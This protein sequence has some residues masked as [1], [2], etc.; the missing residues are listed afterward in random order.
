ML[1]PRLLPAGRLAGMQKRVWT[2][3]LKAVLSLVLVASLLAVAYGVLV[4]G[5]DLFV[6]YDEWD[7]IGVAL[8]VVILGVALPVTATSVV[9]LRLLKH[10]T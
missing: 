8:G 4:L 2:G 7:G 5:T 10:R 3:V 6:E 9:W 1:C